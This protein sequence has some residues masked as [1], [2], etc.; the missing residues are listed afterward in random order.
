MN[1]GSVI[2]KILLKAFSYL[3]DQQKG[4]LTE[5]LALLFY[6]LKGYKPH[7]LNSKGLAEVDLILYK[8]EQLVV[9]EAKFR[10]TQ[11]KA[12]TAIHPSQLQRLKM[13]SALLQRQ[14]PT[15]GIRIDAFLMFPELPIVQNVENIGE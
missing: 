1:T 5:R 10:M 12:Q 8:G 9:V 11:E 2:N 14:F 13:Q 4:N 6:T 15:H 3:S 7:A